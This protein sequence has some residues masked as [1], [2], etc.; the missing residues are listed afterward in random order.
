MSWTTPA[1]LRAQVQKLWDKGGIL[2]SLASG[3]PLFPKRLTLKAPSSTELLD[4][5]EAAR[6]WSQSLRA[7]PGI[8]LELREFRHRVF[9]LNSLPAEAWI[10]DLAS[11]VALIGRQKDTRLF[12]DLLQ[13]TLARQPV[14]R[15][16]LAKRPLRALELA[17][18]WPRLLDV[19][20]WLAGHPR[21]GIYLRQMDV[22]GVHSKFVEAQRGV[23]NELL[24]LALPAATIDPSASGVAQ[25]TRRYGFRDK[26]ERIR[27]RVLDPVCS[28]LAG[29]ALPDLTL[30]ADSF[31]QLGRIAARVFIT[32]N[33]TNFLAFPPVKNSLV[34]FGAGYGFEA[35]GQ[36]SWLNDCRLYYWGD[37]DTHGFAILNELRGRFAHVESFLMDRTTLLAHETLWGE[38]DEATQRELS[39]LNAEESALYDAL[40]DNRIRRNLRLEQER[41]GFGWVEAALAKLGSFS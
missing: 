25:F 14:L 15:A 36:A 24:D 27:L 33:E 39:H 23:L 10:D 1:E 2:A 6:A 17:D 13:L 35:L 19:L 12:T 8:R 16:W 20:D 37:I 28:P 11:A 32:E 7:M 4:R 31:A 26:P 30:D 34:I 41:I 3:E 29:V 9:G 21:P 5:F 18:D 38:E 40:R 22:P